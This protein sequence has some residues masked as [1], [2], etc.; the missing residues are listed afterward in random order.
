MKKALV[1]P[2]TDRELQELYRILIDRD[3]EGA[4]EFLN[5]Y[6]RPAMNKAMEGG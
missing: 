1:I 6:A 4:L 5:V 3:Q 2:V